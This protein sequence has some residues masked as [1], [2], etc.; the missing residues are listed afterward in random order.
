MDDLRR[1]LLNVDARDPDPVIT[2]W[3][4]NGEASAAAEWLLRLIW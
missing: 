2:A 4:R 1:V 3:R